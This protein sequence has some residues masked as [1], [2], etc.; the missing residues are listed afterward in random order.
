MKKKIWTCTV[1]NATNKDV[2]SRYAD[3]DSSY[4]FL[5]SDE[6]WDKAKIVCDFLD[7]FDMVTNLISGTDYPTSNLFLPE[8]WHI[9]TILDEACFSE[10]SCLTKMATKMKMKLDKYWGDYNLLI[11]LVA[12]LDPRNK[13]KFIDFAFGQ[14]YSSDNAIRHLNEVRDCLYKLFEEYM[15]SHK[16]K[17]TEGQSQSESQSQS[18]KFT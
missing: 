11:S 2:F 3:R 4:S 18:S 14:I 5:P 12:I 10:D 9:K 13:L 7:E 15:S 1:D 16:S 6:D 8:L 17:I